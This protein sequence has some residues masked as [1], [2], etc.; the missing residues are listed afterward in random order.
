MYEE[1]SHFSAAASLLTN[2]SPPTAKF[3]LNKFCFALQKIIFFP[4][5]DTSALK[6]LRSQYNSAKTISLKAIAFERK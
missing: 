3:L 6:V 2:L 1:I 5:L 4:A